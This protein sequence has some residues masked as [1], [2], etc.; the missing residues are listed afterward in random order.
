ML[1]LRAGCRAVSVESFVR[2]VSALA[3]RARV[4]NPF[5]P[6]GLYALAIFS[7][8]IG[9]RL[10]QQSI[11][12]QACRE[13]FELS[14]SNAGVARLVSVWMCDDFKT[15]LACRLGHQLGPAP[16]LILHLLAGIRS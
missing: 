10:A 2:A 5:V 4:T 7:H 3:G 9:W 13:R 16:S 1:K 8:F 15:R 12:R 14:L 11:F 6:C